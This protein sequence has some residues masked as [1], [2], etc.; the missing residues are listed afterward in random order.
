MILIIEDEHALAAALGMVCKR[1]GHEARLCSSGQRGLEELGRSEFALAILD[2]GL[3]DMSGLAVLEQMRQRA[4][5]L[6]ALI[7]TAHGNLDNA[8][9][10]KKLGAAAYLVKPLDLRDVQETL[11]QLLSVEPVPVATPGEALSLLIGAA[12]A[13]QRTFVEIAHACS[14]EAP[15]LITG[16]TGTGKTLTARVIHANS[17]RRDAP[18]VTLHCSALPE[19]LLEA[20][21]FGHEKGAFTGAAASR[22][23][24]IER[25]MGGTLFLDE[26]ADVA[27]A[28]QAK[29]L[30][31]VE[32]HT[33]TRVGG[34]E[35][36]HVD[37]RLITAT[38]Q[39]LREQVRAGRFREDLYY[40]LHVLE[41]FLP[42][43]RERL[44][45][46]PALAASF[47][48]QLAPERSIQLAPATLE[49][50]QRHVWPGN[51]R[52][53]RNVLEHAVA[54]SSGG[55]ILPQHLPRDLRSDPSDASD[56]SAP[57]EPA[58]AAWL[59]Q[60]LHDGASYREMHDEVESM[61]L[62]HLLARFGGRPTILARETR[63]N[64]VT[65]R[66]KLAQLESLAEEGEAE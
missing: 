45:D 3:P 42:P 62:R 19:Q 5:K 46:L 10:A 20:E 15:V 8:V 14:T 25:A 60:K 57:L 23:G 61:M 51:V 53:L 4:P 29:L 55:V 35:D 17:A 40:R 52:E 37:L 39:D 30:R 43:L 38:N 66:K 54:V 65:L 47:L 44:G 21:L 50:F 59:D 58:L 24:H 34:R 9:A 32:E 1:L 64:R 6:P 36:L 56:G 12:P 48:R 41:I 7:I 28:I 13:L 27:P 49:Q 63:M 31:F 11:R 18:F 16:P 2:I 33:F 22:A 26:I